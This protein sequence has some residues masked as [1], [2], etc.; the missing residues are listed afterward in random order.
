ME[1]TD[2][3]ERLLALLLLQDM[4]G[5]P[6]RD[7]IRQLNVAGFSNF[8]IADILQTNTAVVAQSLYQLRRGARA[9]KPAV[10]KRSK[11]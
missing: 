3:A 6:Q 8:E 11:S 9:R 5:L 4:K 7:K 1:K 2:R 10:R